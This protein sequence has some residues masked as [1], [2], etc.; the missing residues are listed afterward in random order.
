MQMIRDQI[1]AGRP[2]TAVQGAMSATVG[3]I[4]D[5]VSR[6]H[7]L[8]AAAE[9]AYDAGITE[10]QISSDLSGHDIVEKLRVI[11]FAC[12]CELPAAKVAMKPPFPESA[13]VKV[14]TGERPIQ[15]FEALEAFD[16]SEAFAHRAAEAFKAG[17]RWRFLA[18]LELDRGD[19]TA[20]IGLEEV[21]EDHY[22]FPIRGQEIVCALWEERP[23]KA[24]KAG[25]G[26]VLVIR[27]QG[28]GKAAGEGVLADIVRLV[29]I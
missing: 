12:G 19:A 11:A 4:L 25:S 20:T 29:S 24:D 13:L 23:S 16:Q 17:R 6:G 18:T 7:S 9:E 21:D 8:R 28:A 3:M 27:G 10:P 2:V 22:A 14:K 1:T 15:V 5:R 26:P